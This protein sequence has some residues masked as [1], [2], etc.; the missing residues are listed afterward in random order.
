MFITSAPDMD[1]LSVM[2]TLSLPADVKIRSFK[3]SKIAWLTDSYI[4][5]SMRF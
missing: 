1:S 3:G 4:L 2:I 5:W